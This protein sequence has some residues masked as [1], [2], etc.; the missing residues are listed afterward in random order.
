M[1]LHQ[2]IHRQNHHRG[3][4]HLSACFLKAYLQEGLKLKSHLDRHLQSAHEWTLAHNACTDRWW[5][6]IARLGRYG[7]IAALVDEVFLLF[8]S[9]I[10]DIGDVW[11]WVDTN[12]KST[13]R[14]TKRWPKTRLLPHYQY[15]LVLLALS[16]LAPLDWW[17]WLQRASPHPNLVFWGEEQKSG[18]LWAGFAHRARYLQDHFRWGID[19]F[20]LLLPERLPNLYWFF[21]PPLHAF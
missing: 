11:H 13:L 21:Y 14:R 2:T 16:L 18:L 9:D 7:S 17:P 3:R 10:V 15:P 12:N 6:L 8:V 20:G 19:S 5:L 1:T 4:D